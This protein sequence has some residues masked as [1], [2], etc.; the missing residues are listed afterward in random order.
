MM[1]MMNIEALDTAGPFEVCIIGSGPAGT[2]L[3]TE[4]VQ[5]GVRT[6]IL[7]SGG[8]LLRWMLDSRLRRLAEYQVSGDCD[9]PLK[10]SR[11]RVIGGT[12][13][14]WTGR[15][16]RF[17]PSDFESH[18]Y[19]P[20]D[21]PWPVSYSELDPYYEKA[22]KSLR[23]R[24]GKPSAYAPPRRN[25]LPLPERT[26]ISGLRKIL[27]KAGIVLDDSPTA[28]PSKSIRFFRVQKEILPSF[29]SSSSGILVSG[30]DVTRLL[31]DP[32]RKVTAAE[33]TLPGGT[34]KTVTAKIFVVCCGGIESARLLLVSRNEICPNGIGN[35][36]DWVGRFF[37]E[38]PA[39][40]FYSKINHTPS[41]LYPSNKIGR[42][43]QFYN[44]FRKE[45]LGSVLFVFRQA[46]L[47]PHHNMPLKLS[48]IPKNMVR[49]LGRLRKAT[50]YLGATIEM[51]LSES[52]RV[53]LSNDRFDCFGNPIAHLTLSF[54]EEDRK[55]LEGCRNYIRQFCRKIGASDLVEAPI[56]WSRH[57]QGTCRMGDN[58]RSS[59]VDRNLKV[60]TMSNLY[61]CGSEVFVTGGAMQP[62]LTIA[63]LSHRLADHLGQTLGR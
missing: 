34:R 16:T 57:H 10:N 52:N 54:S 28:T 42:S 8:S 27:G 7:E 22:E 35:D 4:L 58:A 50:L 60:H 36:N 53:T 29:Q 55:T 44:D 12:S 1:A 15:C 39:V 31:V 25:A 21:N 11:A 26:D 32:S 18:P 5:K 62:C 41:T 33:I 3:G 61:V 2:I 47:L 45:G 43:F 17:H 23:V 63:A 20:H 37:N 56:S 13:N 24:G 38:H 40:N 30:V 6:L 48:N 46:W 9:Y 51:S 59:V 19:A 49:V 14:F